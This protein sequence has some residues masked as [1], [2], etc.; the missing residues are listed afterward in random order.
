MSI[1]QC[2]IID[3][4]KQE[5]NQLKCKKYSSTSKDTQNKNTKKKVRKDEKDSCEKKG[6][7]EEETLKMRW[8]KNRGS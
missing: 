2:T 5:E 7:Q 6:K 4:E 1:G 8:G 3:Q